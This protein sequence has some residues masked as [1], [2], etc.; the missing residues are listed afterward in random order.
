[1][2]SDIKEAPSKKRQKFKPTPTTPGTATPSGAT[3]AAAPAAPGAGPGAG[4]DEA[5]DDYV[6]RTWETF[7]ADSNLAN[8]DRDTGSHLQTA[9]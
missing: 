4:P 3:A 1:M 2:A 8:Q 7:V 6:R 9:L 5:G